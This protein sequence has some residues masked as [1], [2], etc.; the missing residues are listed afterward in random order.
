MQNRHQARPLPAASPGVRP[1][2]QTGQAP[3]KEFIPR[4]IL[5]QVCSF[6]FQPGRQIEKPLVTKWCLD[7]AEGESIEVDDNEVELVRLVNTKTVDTDSRTGKKIKSGADG[8]LDLTDNEVDLVEDEKNSISGQS[9]QRNRESKAF[10]GK[11][12]RLEN[13][14]SKFWE[15]LISFKHIC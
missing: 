15:I 3:H 9:D 2:P 14:L 5:F 6:G 11:K 8:S 12:K 7:T 13:V 1:V 10:D 4:K